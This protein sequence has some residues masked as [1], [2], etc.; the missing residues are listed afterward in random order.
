[1]WLWN[2]DGAVLPGCGTKVVN[3]SWLVLP[4]CGT[5]KVNYDLLVEPR[6]WSIT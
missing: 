3:S 5:K 2:Q 1:M 6:W 4:G